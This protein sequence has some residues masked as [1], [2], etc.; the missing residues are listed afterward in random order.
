MNV[1]TSNNRAKIARA[2]AAIVIML[3]SGVA[4]TESTLAPLPLDI[5]LTASRTIAAPGDTILFVA[6]VQGGSLLGLDADYGD[7]TADQYGTAG[8]R[9][10]KVTFR[11]AYTARGIFTAK[12]TVTDATLGQ[13]NA[14][15]EIHVN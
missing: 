8:A 15:I 4:C 1:D 13:K 12:I 6:T 11:H 10:G 5:A 7:S 3:A 9:T 14:S 2:A